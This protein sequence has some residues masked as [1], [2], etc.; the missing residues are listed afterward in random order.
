MGKAFPYLGQLLVLAL[1]ALGLHFLINSI[2]KDLPF[3]DTAHMHLWQIYA[4]QFLLS[5]IIVLGVVG[6]GNA[7]PNNLGFVF[8]GFLTLKILVNYL[9]L[10]PALQSG[11]TSNFFK[12]NYLAVFFLFVFFDVYVTYRVL[13]Q[14]YPSKNNK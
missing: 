6:I 2:S 8:L 4:L 13:N 11:D 9:V 1:I 5:A 7:M 3:W 14:I 12:Y 10:N